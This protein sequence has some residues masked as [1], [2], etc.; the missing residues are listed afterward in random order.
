MN[1]WNKEKERITF[2]EN[3]NIQ[4]ENIV[5]V[6]LFN[7]SI[8]VTTII[9]YYANLTNYDITSKVIFY[10]IIINF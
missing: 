4:T 3:F 1:F 7:K 6:I 8:S 5:Q 9:S 10:L 2:A